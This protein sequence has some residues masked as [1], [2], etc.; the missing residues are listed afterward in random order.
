MQRWRLMQWKSWRCLCPVFKKPEMQTGKYTL[1]QQ[2]FHQAGSHSLEKYIL[3][4]RLVYCVVIS[5]LNDI[6][7][8]KMKVVL[9][10]G[11]AVEAE[12]GI[13]GDALAP[14][15]VRGPGLARLKGNAR[16]CGNPAGTWTAMPGGTGTDMWTVH[17]PR[18]QW[19]ETSTTAKSA[20]SC[21]L[22]ALC[23][24]RVWGTVFCFFLSSFIHIHFW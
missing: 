15:P 11:V 12:S 13:K 10:R 16:E 4:Y 8:Q 22:V 3:G 2:F 7:G 18:S 19:L 14:G 24:W 6:Q 9:G 20:A 1:N 17:P 5:I 23:S 21:S